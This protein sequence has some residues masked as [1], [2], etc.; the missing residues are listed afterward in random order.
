MILT[1]RE[2]AAHRLGM[3]D[4]LLTGHETDSDDLEPEAALILNVARAEQ[5]ARRAELAPP[6]AWDKALADA[7]QI[8]ADNASAT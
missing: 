3:L 4:A 6:D 5:A 8:L 2:H 7:R 1:A